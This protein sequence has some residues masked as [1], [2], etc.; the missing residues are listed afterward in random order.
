[1]ELVRTSELMTNEIENLM[2]GMKTKSECKNIKYWIWHT[3]YVATPQP[4]PIICIAPID[5]I[6][7]HN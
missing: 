5:I 7:D 2:M 1:M 3:N 6:V 4:P